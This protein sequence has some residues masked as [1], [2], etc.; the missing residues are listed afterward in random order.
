MIPHVLGVAKVVEDAE[1]CAVPMNYAKNFD[2]FL[3]VL[4]G[5]FKHRSNQWFDSRPQQRAYGEHMA[6]ATAGRSRQP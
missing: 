3:K 1:A 5:L 2:D 6:A 4:S